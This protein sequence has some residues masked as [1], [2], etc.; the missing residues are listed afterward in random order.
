MLPCLKPEKEKP[1]IK[2]EP[3]T[4]P[5]KTA[6]TEAP[7]LADEKSHPESV[8]EN[9]QEGRLGSLRIHQSGK[10]TLQMGNHSFVIDSATQVSYLQVRTLDGKS[11]DPI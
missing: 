5:Q 8:F 1:V 4:I 9:T 7:S 10:I 2:V 3:G 11:D 6:V